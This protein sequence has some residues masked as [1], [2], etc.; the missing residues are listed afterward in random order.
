MDTLAATR[1]QVDGDNAFR[2]CDYDKSQLMD[3]LR[4]SCGEPFDLQ[5]KRYGQI[6]ASSTIP[7]ES[8]QHAL[9]TSSKPYFIL[10]NLP[11]ELL[12]PDW[13]IGDTPLV[14]RILLGV[15]GCLGLRPFGYRQEK[16]GQ[17]LHDIFPIPGAEKTFSNAG[18]VP[19]ELHTENPYLPR[20]ARPTVLVLLALNN[21]SDTATQ[22]VCA[23][24]IVANL[25][26]QHEEALRQ[27]IFSF[28]QS[29]SFELNGYS[30][31]ANKT[32]VLKKV[33]GG[34]ELRW[35]ITTSTTDAVGQK[36]IVE[37]HRV[38]QGEA[39]NVVL[40]HGELLVFNNWRCL[41]GRGAVQGKRWLK[42]VYGTDDDSL[43]GQDGLIDVWRA[44][45][46]AEIDHSF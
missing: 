1:S 24:D 22:L 41:H 10:T 35:G 3:A 32:P 39:M 27:P 38:S 34:N 20:V 12:A 33:N 21:D 19:F 13:Q 9:W 4:E 28:R 6:I 14:S 8:M 46:S 45:F 43:V 36:A 31:Y 26:N 37:F 40:K 2:M 17:I 11:H 18:R 30:V 7:V 29:D 15:L 5:S 44:L 25:S 23:E 42:R 16:K